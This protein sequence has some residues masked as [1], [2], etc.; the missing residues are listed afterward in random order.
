M[1]SKRDIIDK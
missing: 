1:Q